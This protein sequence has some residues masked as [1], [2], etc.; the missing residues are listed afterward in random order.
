MKEILIGLL[1]GG[2]VGI[3]VELLSRVNKK[4]K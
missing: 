2:L 4:E 1:V 3:V